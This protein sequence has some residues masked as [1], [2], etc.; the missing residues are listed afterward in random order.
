MFVIAG[1]QF[2][3]RVK[4]EAI[5]RD[6]GAW[7]LHARAATIVALCALTNVFKFCKLG[8][9]DGSKGL[10]RQRDNAVTYLTPM[11]GGMAMQLY[12]FD[13]TVLFI[14]AL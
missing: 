2:H 4:S 13:T 3:R 10:D 11:H 9:S 8:N 5:S 7:K 1:A 6:R 14:S 12:H